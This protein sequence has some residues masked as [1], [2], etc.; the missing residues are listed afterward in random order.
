MLHSHAWPNSLHLT[1]K[2]CPSVITLLK[3]H[4]SHPQRQKCNTIACESLRPVRISIEASENN[5]HQ[6]LP[7][8]AF[9]L[10]TV[11]SF[12]RGQAHPS[13]KTRLFLGAQRC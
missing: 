3:K 13:P 12:A 6:T 8:P 9:S 4:I 11:N 2:V 7:H 1:H 10:A 5:H